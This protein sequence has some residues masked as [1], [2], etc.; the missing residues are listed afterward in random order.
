MDSKELAES[1]LKEAPRFGNGTYPD[2]FNKGDK[3]INFVLRFLYEAEGKV[4]FGD[5]AKVAPFSTARLAALLNKMEERGLVQRTTSK[6]DARKT[7]VEITDEGRRYK[8]EV[9]KKLVQGLARVIDEMGEEDIKEI[10]RLL[11]KLFATMKKVR[12]E[13][14]EN[15]VQTI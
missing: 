2:A 5:I 13:C 15:D 12:E 4:T 11:I 1:L 9:H 8:D 14:E 10:H 7:Y 3:G 6:K